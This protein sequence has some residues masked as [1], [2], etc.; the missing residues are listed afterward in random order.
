MKVDLCLYTGETATAKA[1]LNMANKKPLSDNTPDTSQ[2]YVRCVLDGG[3]A[4]DIPLPHAVVQGADTPNPIYLGRS[5]KIAVADAAKLV[6]LNSA[7]EG[8]IAYVKTRTSKR[9]PLGITCTSGHAVEAV[10]DYMHDGTLTANV[11]E[12]VALPIVTN[13]AYAFLQR[14]KGYTAQCELGAIVSK[15]Y[16]YV[17]PLPISSVL[18]V[19]EA[20]TY[21]TNYR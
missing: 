2:Q 4:F 9:M 18:H 14:L 1:V 7:I 11:L 15:T 21:A 6:E 8:L 19:M 20:T 3:Q 10:K 13:N 5:A 17:A 16:V 12:R